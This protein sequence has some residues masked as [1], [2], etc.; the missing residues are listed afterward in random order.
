MIL[1]NF[2]ENTIIQGIIGSLIASFMTIGIIESYKY[3]KLYLYRKRFSNIFGTYDKDKLNLVIPVLE[4]RSDVI[5]LMQTSTLP[6]S[7]FPLEKYGGA[8]FKSSKL[9]PYADTISLKYVLDIIA[10]TLGSKSIIM[11]DEDLQNKLDISLI[12]FGGSSNYCK[13]VLNQEDNNFYIFNGNTIV[14][15]KDPVKSFQS[16]STYDYGFIIKYRPINFPNKTW[17]IIAGL[18]EYGT[19]GAGWFLSKYWRQ[20]SESFKDAPFGILIRVKQ[21]IDDSAK[22]VDR[23][24]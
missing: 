9:L 23:I 13:Y 14:R 20:L 3:Y 18:G 11:T 10:T 21:G 6:G 2:L 17:I 7:Q 12:S 8:H 5:Q 15:K 24:S 4:I 1:C 16:D 19:R 22:E